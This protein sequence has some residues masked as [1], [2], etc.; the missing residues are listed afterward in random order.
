[1]AHDLDLV[2]SRL[3][4]AILSDCLDSV[5]RMESGAAIAHPPAG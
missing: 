5:R 1:M 3:F 4:T 2:R